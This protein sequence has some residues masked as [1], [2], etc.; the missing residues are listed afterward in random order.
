MNKVN[1]DFEILELPEPTDKLGVLKH[2]ERIGRVCYKSEDKITDE[3]CL[4]F[5]EMIRNRKHWAM[6]EHYIFVLSVP[7]EVFVDIADRSSEIKNDPYYENAIKF[8]NFTHWKNDTSYNQKYEFLISLSFTTINNIISS[9]TCKNTEFITEIFSVWKFLHDHFPEAVIDL[10]NPNFNESKIDTDNIEFL[11]RE[12]IKSLP[13]KLR[14]IHDSASVMFRT[15]R[16]VTHELVRHRPASW[17]QEST[18]YCNYHSDKFDNNIT[19]LDPLFFKERE[20]LYNEWVAAIEDS[21]KHYNKLIELGAVPQE[22]RSIL[23]HSTKVDII[24][25]ARMI[26]FVHFFK[27][28]VPKTAHPQMREIAVPLLKEMHS[29]E[30]KIFEKLYNLYIK[31]ENNEESK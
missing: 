4:K 19:F 1:A 31:G 26:E 8:I 29:R 25:T 11:S 10:E 13:N 21:E 15:D 5:I 30:T 18:R 12:E 6:L 7:Y 23:P 16:G 3:S 17:A 27:M 2:I 20:E 28:R 9:K 14:L 22:A 24:F